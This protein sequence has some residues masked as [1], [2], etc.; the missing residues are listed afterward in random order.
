MEYS[1]KD[2]Y[3]DVSVYL[4][5]PAKSMSNVDRQRELGFCNPKSPVYFNNTYI[6]QRGCLPAGVMDV[7][8][9]LPGNP[10]IY[11][12]QPHFFGSS[13]ALREALIG[14]R[15]PN[16]DDDGTVIGIEPIS[17][18]VVFAQQRTQLNLG[19][20]NGGLFS[21]KHLTSQII[22]MVWFNETASFDSATRA[23]LLGLDHV[24]SRTLVVGILFYVLM[25]AAIVGFV[26]LLVVQRLRSQSDHFEHRLLFTDEEEEEDA[27]REPLSAIE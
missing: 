17:G 4:Y 1:G 14:M 19:V 26:S 21:L 27:H 24:R 12:S 22:P 10:K 9:C 8:S 6:Q 20:I 7:S 2:S 15:L 16:I 13:A 25:A 3:Q 5:Q 23:Q 18:A 11:M